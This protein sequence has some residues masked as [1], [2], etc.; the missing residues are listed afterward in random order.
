MIKRTSD[1]EIMKALVNKFTKIV[2]FVACLLANLS[3]FAIHEEVEV[4]NTGLSLTS[5]INVASSKQADIVAAPLTWYNN[6]RFASISNEI[7]FGID[8]EIHQVDDAYRYK[9]KFNVSGSR[10]DG[11]T[12][13]SFSETG[14]E[15]ELDYSPAGIY[16]DKQVYS[17]EG[18]SDV[19]ISGIQLYKWDPIGGTYV[20]VTV[21]RENLYF[22]ARIE[23]E[24]YE[25]FDYTS[26]PPSTG[27]ALTLSGDEMLISLP[28]IDGAEHYDLEW[29]WVNRY[30]G[31]VMGGTP[32]LF[33][34][35]EVSYDFKTN[36]SRVRINTPSYSIPMIYGD[37][38]LLVR[39]RGVGRIVTNLDVNIEGAWMT[40]GTTYGDANVVDV[41]PSGCYTTVSAIEGHKINYGASMTFIEN[42]R[43]NTSIN[44]TDGLMK[45]RQ[46][47]S[48]INSQ[49]E[50]LVGSVIYD[51]YGRPAIGVM[52]SPVKETQLGYVEKL[53]MYDATT[54]YDKSVF[55]KDDY[56]LGACGP[57]AAPPMDPDASAGAANY[58]SSSNTNKD[59]AEAFL[60]EANGYT[61][62][63][64]H[65]TNDPTGRAKR[66]GSVGEDHQLDAT[67]D[68]YTQVMTGAQEDPL[69]LDRYFGS[70]AAHFSN[71]SR[72]ITRDVHGQISVS[73]Q[74]NFGRTVMNYLSGTA[75][76][77]LEAIHGNT[78][79]SP[80]DIEVDLTEFTSADAGLIDAGI[81][82]VDKKIIVEDAD[83]VYTFKYDFE[84]LSFTDCL[85]IDV[86][87]D[88]IYEIEFEVVPSEGEFTVDCPL[89]DGTLAIP[90]SWSYTV[91]SIT[92]FNIDCETP[93]VFS[94]LHDETFTLQ[95][96]RVDEYY[97]RKTLKVSEAPIEYYWDQYVENA[98][99]ECL[100]PYS[101]FLA[102]AMLDID[103]SD[104]Y[105]GSPCE[106][107]FLYEYG[108]FEEWQL[109]T[110]GTAAAYDVLRE[111]YLED[112]QNQPICTQML[113]ILLGDVSPGGQYGDISGASGLS[114]F[115]ASDPMDFSWRDVTFLNDDGTPATTTNVSGEEVAVN[116]AS[117]SLTEFVA[118]WNP[119][120]AEVLLGAH[121][122]YDTYE[123]CSTYASI[124]EYATA[125]NSTETY[126]DAV[127][128]GF[129]TPVNPATYPAAFGGSPEPFTSGD[130]LINLINTITP[131]GIR[132]WMQASLYQYDDSYEGGT[133]DYWD[134]A[135]NLL[136]LTGGVTLYQM[137]SAASDGT[138]FGSST[139]DV[140]AQWQAFK[141]LYM[142]RRNLILQIAMEGYALQTGGP[143]VS[144]IA[145]T[146]TICTTAGYSAYASKT[147]LFL[148]YDQVM[149]YSFLEMMSDPLVITDME[150]A[151]E[152]ETI[153]FCQTAC[154]SM[155]YDWMTQL[156]SCA[157]ELLVGTWAEGN[158]TYDAIKADLITVCKGGCST[159]WPF[160]SQYDAG[161]VGY[162]TSFESV[163]EHYLALEGIPA[164][165]I[166]CNHYLITS[167]SPVDSLTLLRNL[168][169][170]GCDMLLSVDSEEAFEE[171]YGFIPANFCLER[172]KCAD[173]QGVSSTSTYGNGSLNWTPSQIALVE[174]ETSMNDY[175][176][177]GDGCID[178]EELSTAITAFLI[179]FPTASMEENPI[180]F[181]SFV[182]EMFGTNFN[183]YS[184]VTFKEHCDS[185]AVYGDITEGINPEAYEFVN[186]MNTLILG[187]GLY[188]EQFQPY[189]EFPALVVSSNLM[190]SSTTGVEQ[191][192]YLPNA[193][194]G[195]LDPLG[196]TFVDVDGGC[197]ICIQYLFSIYPE[198]TVSD[199]G[200]YTSMADVLSNV[201]SFESLYATYSDVVATDN[202]F[203]VT[204]LVTN[205]AGDDPLVIEFQFISGCIDA[206]GNNLGTLCDNLVPYEED[207]CID[208]LIAN[209]EMMAEFEYGEYL[210]TMKEQFIEDYIEKCSQVE[211]TYTYSF[212]A[213]RYHR[214]LFYY[215][216]AGNLVKTVSPK[217]VAELS[218]AQ[219]MEVKLD[220][221]G[222]GGS[223]YFP[224]HSFQTNY[225][226]NGL[227]Q[228]VSM[229]TPDGG[230]TKFWYDNIGR[231]VVSQ[232]ARQAALKS[233]EID[234]DPLSLTFTNLPAYSYTRFDEL[235]RPIEFGEFVQPT[236]LTD[237]TA[238]NPTAL[239]NWLFQEAVVGTPRYRNQVTRINYSNPTSAEAIAALG[240]DQG[241]I[242][243]R[244]SS[245][246]TNVD[247]VL[248]SS[249][250]SLP[251]PDYLNHYAYDIHGNVRDFVQ[252]MP[253]LAAD[254]R[255]F[256]HTEYEYDLLS[257][258]PHYV[259]FQKG[260]VDQFSHNFIYDAD[261]R[262]KEVYT[263]K[264]GIIWD[265][266]AEYTYRLDGKRSRTE[267]GDVEVQ[268]MDYAYTLHGWLKALNS[269][270]LDP[271]KD[272]G[273]DGQNFGIGSS[274]SAN[275]N[276]AQDALAFTMGY[277]DG[278]YT[279][280]DNANPLTNF[281]PEMASSPFQTDRISLYNGNISSVTTAMMD[282]DEQ[283][284]D[285]TGNTY[286]YDQLHR[287]RESH[288]FTSTDITELNSFV[289]A[290]RQNL[291]AGTENTLGDYEVRI[292]YDQ[293]G[294]IEQLDRR[295]KDEGFG[296][297]KM[298][299]FT[300]N[301][302]ST[303]NRLEFVKDA[304][305]GTSYGDIQNGQELY[306]DNNYQYHD[307]GSLKSDKQEE[308]A[309]I[310]WYPNG[311]LKRI[312]REESS[313]LSDLYFEYDPMG[314]RSLKLEMTKDGSGNLLASSEWNYSWYTPDANGQTMA[315]YQRK[316]G[317][318]VL[319]RSE[320]IIYGASR[321]GLDTRR[322]EI[323]PVDESYSLDDFM[324]GNP[325]GGAG[326]WYMLEEP[327][328]TYSLG[329]V[330][331]DAETDLYVSNTVASDF[332]VYLT[333]NT[334]IGETYTVEFD[335]LSMTVPG[336]RERARRCT[337]T[338]LGGLDISTPGSYSHTFVA[339]DTKSQIQ[340]RGQG[341]TGNFVLSNIDVTGP[342]D[343]FADIPEAPVEFAVI[344]QR[345]LGEKLF[346][347]GDHLGNVKEVITDRTLIDV[348]V[349][350]YTLAEDFT[351]SP[352]SC[353][354]A[355]T[356]YFNPVGT[357]TAV[358]ED[359]DVDGDN[360]DLTVSHPSSTNFLAFLS[361]A[362]VPSETYTVSYDVLNQTTTWLK[363]RAQSCS[364]GG[365][366]GLL[367]G[368]GT[369]S[370]SYTFTATTTQTK[371]FWAAQGTGGGTFTLGNISVTGAGDLFGD[372]D[373]EELLVLLP[374]VVSYS[375][376]YPYGMEMPNRHGSLAD[377]RYAFNGMEA[378]NEVSG[379]G[380]SLDFGARM[381][382]PRLG[383]WKTVDPKFYLQPAW[384]PYK[385][386]LDNPI[387]YTDPKGETEYLT[388]LI[389]NKQTGKQTYITIPVSDDLDR[390]HRF[391]NGLYYYYDF[392]RVYTITIEED[393]STSTHM[394]G[395]IRGNLRTSGI[396]GSYTI[397][398]LAAYG[399]EGDGDYQNGGIHLV[400]KSGGASPTKTISRNN[401][402]TTEAEAL[403]AML[404]GF[405]SGGAKNIYEQAK[406]AEAFVDKVLQADSEAETNIFSEQKS[407]DYQYF[408]A[409][410]NALPSGADNRVQGYYRKLTYEDGTVAWAQFQYS[411]AQTS[412]ELKKQYG[413]WVPSTA[414]AE[415]TQNNNSSNS[416]N[417]SGGGNKQTTR[418][419]PKAKF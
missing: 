328:T 403:I 71:Y 136:N 335:V 225:F 205:P 43:R 288:V 299:E 200:G 152:L 172:E 366:L 298:D 271:N 294:N 212:Q 343:V 386:M 384:S 235:G 7:I 392:S 321:V 230:T 278:D 381:Y 344:N 204:G 251:M 402:E 365:N 349:D 376:Y 162:L 243:N 149:P 313:T 126:A 284:L 340:W 308:I 300:Y 413:T 250:W 241:D 285:V 391:Q 229:T 193:S 320:A 350:E 68:H 291:T 101:A 64:V 293:N 17:F 234:G 21:D 163:I 84:A 15:L 244:V 86:C 263:S 236:A 185:L 56:M 141:Q 220:R 245:V 27:V 358:V 184:L 45:S 116:H 388:I 341:S 53:N 351:V 105:E 215:D 410:G 104:C 253:D 255:Q 357:T 400:S 231:L 72:V 187:G 63:Q 76:M 99:V 109:E 367:D 47:I 186:F 31:T 160:P 145:Y 385:S 37:G 346:E 404:G 364:G 361:I 168:S 214:T 188:T 178:C 379:D 30:D 277:F 371:L 377:Y 29:T 217:G 166:D 94:D 295:A 316:G 194:T 40:K 363:A 183:Y 198:G 91:G 398:K 26:V 317:D 98:S 85:P 325:C 233:S 268:G 79:E 121:P 249:G 418:Y 218:N 312:F 289:N 342:G 96:P 95:F 315:V 124:F 247:Y 246:A 13:T 159:D 276:V 142:A 297:N 93:L 222:L 287:L 171:T 39:Y 266:D 303:S 396:S 177:D 108:T 407:D 59:G 6:F 399:L 331:A 19:S 1:K 279:R 132:N 305:S 80:T 117:I 419:S 88:C 260:E 74:D 143:E 283:R 311:K 103:Y 180:M 240:G 383:R 51:H 270:V 360:D 354:D 38:F 395:R 352:T 307:D 310:E 338:N 67:T 256:F 24:Y 258:L 2:A 228:P 12:V 158:A 129:I 292:E 267:L 130:P 66:I 147:K 107:N 190:C 203:H 46:Q 259:H 118:L 135:Q 257:G 83:Q 120:W 318:P 8:Q 327:N 216:V 111:E 192:Q 374:D 58:Y 146:S 414:P 221:A 330:N 314:S 134:A 14:I 174:A 252:Q 34:T 165:T 359:Y 127:A 274:S 254:G 372:F 154:E 264:D 32:V 52:G 55:H 5:S 20:L 73:I 207:D 239:F 390:S 224:A 355:G 301:Y 242:R 42:G 389:D 173:I 405:S 226:Y 82:M 81:L 119:N 49:E 164:E 157:A 210:A 406:I 211:E 16:Q 22:K 369:G 57:M 61:F 10:V 202:R 387:I 394:S 60:P 332:A 223:E 150:D 248:M 156:E 11:T 281:L 155:A 397:A 368:T 106:L 411:S 70:E 115:N 36:A 125:F 197:P 324:L 62:T 182:N 23:S 373:S 139:C 272:M 25:D 195:A 416:G 409:N 417:T 401:V 54:P 41:Y 87:F 337:G 262:L 348:T 232:N 378:D 148:L 196:F 393:G 336:I 375:D 380:N 35:T 161:G 100:I 412:M 50:L 201:I 206:I 280:I 306:V 333:V 153:D 319:F 75:P 140:D 181:T 97:I 208:D 114:V 78:P 170:C 370:Y 90:S 144:C 261:N 137:A 102:D 33:A 213:N 334:E 326:S 265:R 408:D 347:L 9:I 176:C 167:P 339:L 92:D 356:W 290:A 237:A 110:G 77:E 128:N 275:K 209:A 133:N 345:I 286:R 227:N 323:I 18:G 69:E 28:A 353:G 382:D 329:D 199:W 362:T 138:A 123:F 191:I 122:E 269:G 282:L 169:T 113:P 131:S 179:E 296:S 4:V 322:V 112:C 219:I 44:F 65:Y 273:K 189:E 304:I 238:K 3:V 415:N 302:P 48:Q 175:G 89:K 151:A 309:Y